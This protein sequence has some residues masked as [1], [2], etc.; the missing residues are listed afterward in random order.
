MI[1][2][3]IFITLT[4]LVG[5]AGWYFSGQAHAR[6]RREAARESEL[7][8]A[9]LRDRAAEAE[10]R[11]IETEERLESTRKELQEALNRKSALETEAARLP[12]AEKAF[13]E[14]RAQATSDALAL[15]EALT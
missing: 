12:E 13:R 7:E 11:R 1:L 2:N 10:R 6:G 9:P 15:R 14:L 3:A 5:A 8:T 4:V